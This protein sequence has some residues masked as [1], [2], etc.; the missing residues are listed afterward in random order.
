MEPKI[1]V[2]SVNLG[3]KGKVLAYLNARVTFPASQKAGGDKS[4]EIVF[5][6]TLSGLKVIDGAKGKF[7]DAPARKFKGKGFIPFYFPNKALKEALTQAG[8]EAYEKKAKEESG[9]GK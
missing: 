5:G 7:L 2:L 4:G 6:I 8:L 3:R 9:E 1:E